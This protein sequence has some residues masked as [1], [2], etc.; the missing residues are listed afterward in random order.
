MII[1]NYRI[2]NHTQ[3]EAMF[4][5]KSMEESLHIDEIEVRSLIPESCGKNS[6]QFSIIWN[7]NKLFSR[8]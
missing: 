2:R 5:A 7:A 1:V 8:G 4:I 3:R 6:F